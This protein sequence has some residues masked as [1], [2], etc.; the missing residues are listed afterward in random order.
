VRAR[1]GRPKTRGASAN[2]DGAVARLRRV[3]AGSRRNIPV[4]LLTLA[5]SRPAPSP[6]SRGP[7]PQ[8]S[9]SGS[10]SSDSSRRRPG[11]RRDAAATSLPPAEDTAKA[12]LNESQRHAELATV[13]VR[14]RRCVSGSSIPSEGRCSCRHGSTR[15]IGHHRTGSAR[16]RISCRRRFSSRSRPICSRQGAGGGGRTPTQAVTTSRRR[17]RSRARRGDRS[18]G[19]GGATGRSPDRAANGKS[20]SLGFCWGGSTSFAWAVAQP[21][22]PRPSSLRDRARRSLE[23]VGRE[24]TRL[25]STV[26]ATRGSTRRSRQPR[27]R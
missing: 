25:V 11:S 21:G 19:R 20:A 7:W 8:R 14:A 24:G 17:S 13:D 9:T 2:H 1:T 10:P 27:R 26:A 4:V 16:S 23:A 12:R 22:S 5:E 18:P 3:Q 6:A 15:S